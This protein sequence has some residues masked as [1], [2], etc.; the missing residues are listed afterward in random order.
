[1]E[2]YPDCYCHSKKIMEGLKSVHV[3]RIS[4]PAAAARVQEPHAGQVDGVL[5][6]DCG[7]L[8]RHGCNGCIR[9]QG[10]VYALCC[11]LTWTQTCAL[12]EGLSVELAAD[13]AIV[14]GRTS[15]AAA[16]ARIW[17]CME[18]ACLQF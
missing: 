3:V 9:L 17:W 15:G 16:P 10:S 11:M 4:S 18:M 7:H 6:V 14:D 2:A 5:C 1:M 8:W 13:R 12:H